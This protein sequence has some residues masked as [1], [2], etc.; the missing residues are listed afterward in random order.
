MFA[1]VISNRSLKENQWDR[2]D[3]FFFFLSLNE[4]LVDWE[5]TFT[6]N[7]ATA[8]GKLASVEKRCGILCLVM[9]GLCAKP[10]TG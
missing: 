7:N 5:E 3:D 6:L 2:S 8:F 4:L 9:P 1:F 10:K